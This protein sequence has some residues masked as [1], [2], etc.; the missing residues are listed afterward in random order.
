VSHTPTGVAA[1]TMT[2][3]IPNTEG[4]VVTTRTIPAEDTEETQDPVIAAPAVLE[5]A[6]EASEVGRRGISPTEVAVAIGHATTT[7]STMTVRPT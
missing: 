6:G 3:A 5:T 2:T 4:I 1:L 7:H